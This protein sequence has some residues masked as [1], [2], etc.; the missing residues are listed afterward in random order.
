MWFKNK[1]LTT[2]VQM[3]LK[4]SNQRIV[5]LAK[6]YGPSSPTFKK[7]VGI[8]FSGPMSEYRTE[9][10]ITPASD[11]VRRKE[12]VEKVSYP[13]INIRKVNQDIRSGRLS[14]SEANNILGKLAGLKIDNEG[15]AR[16]TKSGGAVKTVSQIREDIKKRLR[17]LGDN[18]DDVLSSIESE[19]DLE[20]MTK[21]QKL[22]IVGQELDAFAENFQTAY[23]EATS[24]VKELTTL[25]KNNK[26]KYLWKNNRGKRKL[27]YEE[28]REIKE[29]LSK[30]AEQAREDA[31]S[32]EDDNAED[33]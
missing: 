1:L 10:N 32:F 19:E 9:S 11:Y 24:R 13:K 17:R 33:V 18:I 23:N 5:Q 6:T 26:T 22:D 3:A 25:T 20:G 4:K 29:E 2:I 7:E 28:L 15:N 16:P 31:T 21:N 8:I 14:L 12:G 30:I 27:T